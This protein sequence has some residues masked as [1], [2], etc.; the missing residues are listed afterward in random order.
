LAPT[1]ISIPEVDA[2]LTSVVKQKQQQK[3]K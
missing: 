1:W 2:T 3:T